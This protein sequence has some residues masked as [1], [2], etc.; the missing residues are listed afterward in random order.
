MTY[1]GDNQFVKETVNAINYVSKGDKS[2]IIEQ[3]INN[4]KVIKIKNTNIGND[5]YNP[6]TNTVYYN[7]QSGLKCVDENG[8]PTGEKQ[9]PALGL[10]HELGHGHV[11]INMSKDEKKGFYILDNN[12]HTKAE[13]YVIEN[14]ETPAAKILNEGTRNNHFGIPYKTKNST[15]I[16]EVY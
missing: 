11:D 9:T 4:E 6:L 13:K 10:Y 8:T 16:E 1:K 14:L 2:N 5:R 3:L 15:S 7:P 12:Y